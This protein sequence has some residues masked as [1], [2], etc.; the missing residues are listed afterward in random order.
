MHIKFIIMSINKS[1]LVLFF[2]SRF[3]IFTSNF[4]NFVLFDAS[5]RIWSGCFGLSFCLLYNFWRFCRVQVW[6]SFNP[7]FWRD[8]IFIS[9]FVWGC[10]S[11]W[12]VLVFEIFSH[13]GIL[14]W[15][16]FWFLVSFSSRLY[17]TL[18]LTF[19]LFWFRLLIFVFRTIRIRIVTMMVFVMMF[20]FY[21]LHSLTNSSLIHVL[22]FSNRHCL[23]SRS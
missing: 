17:Q 3:L 11:L 5:C 9:A 20:V 22:S 16:A 10:I 23:S 7:T 6:S 19:L 2:I 14:L 1:I 12:F 15:G 13:L 8:S 18:F 4:F 21:G